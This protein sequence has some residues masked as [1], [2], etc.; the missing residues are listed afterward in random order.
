MT[1]ALSAIALGAVFIALSILALP[2]GVAQ[3]TAGA[4]PAP[5]PYRPGLGD[6]M[7]MTVQ[8]RHIKLAQAGREKNWRYA[9]Y[10]HHELEE[11]L[12]RVARYWPQWRRF[13]IAST[14]TSVTKEPMAA[15]SR[16]IKGADA[17]AYDTAYRQLTDGCNSCHQAANVG[18]NAIVVPNVSTF[19]DQD[20][21][22]AKP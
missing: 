5:S 6:L 2:I 15:L 18:F 17:H 19:P 7:T 8:P 9:A 12:E 13:P 21:R 11:A 1:R 10:E 14:M 22:A 3:T 20:F 4:Q 16:A